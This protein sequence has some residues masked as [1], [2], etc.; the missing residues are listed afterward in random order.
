MAEDA[1][2]ATYE[3]TEAL[4]GLERPPPIRRGARDYLAHLATI[5]YR[6]DIRPDSWSFWALAPVERRWQQPAH[7]AQAEHVWLLSQHG[8]R[9]YQA[10]VDVETGDIL[11]RRRYD[12]ETDSRQHMTDDTDTPSVSPC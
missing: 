12:P 11:R 4:F 1:D 3:Q 9:L 5:R 7:V 6:D 8:S 10:L 2:I